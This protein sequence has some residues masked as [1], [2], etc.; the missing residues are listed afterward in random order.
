MRYVVSRKLA[1][2]VMML[3]VTGACTQDPSEIGSDFFTGGSLDF[4]SIDSASVSLSTVMFEDLQSNN[5][6]RLLVGSHNDSKLGKIQAKTFF[7]VNKP[8]SLTFPES[9]L[10]YQYCAIVLKYEGYTY[11]D[12][13]TTMTLR[14]HRVLEDFELEDDAYLY[15]DSE[16]LYQSS[17]M[18]ELTFT[19]RPHKDDSLEIKLPDT[20]GRDLYDKALNND[21]V[22]RTNDD[23][24]EWLKGFAIVSEYNDA[25][26]ILGFGIAPELRVYYTDN[27]EVPSVTKYISLPRGTAAYYFNN[28][29]SD[30]SETNIQLTSSSDRLPSEKSDDESYIQSGIG[31]ALRVE[32]P[33][34]RD[35]AQHENVFITQAILEIY[36]VRRSNENS[37]PI[38]N[39]LKPYVIDSRNDVLGE[40]TTDAT[41]IEDLE[42]ERTTRYWMD[43]TAFVKN[44]IS[45]ED[46]N[47]DA[48]A[49]FTPEFNHVVDRIYVNAAGTQYKTRLL[50]YYTMVNQ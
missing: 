25:G 18:G 40:L 32:F 44:Q 26:T 41:L 2:I 1:V 47:E 43:V 13:A 29:T 45:R 42:L 35:F 14:V 11:Y 17:P 27:N 6:T 23:L 49:F 19:P 16:V 30:Q 33:H 21:D 15:N 38:P 24:L 36:P 9:N 12:T 31:L 39:Y 7:Q 48:L 37:A 20:F 4:S 50:M 5:S 28:I 10:T 46:S 8:S 22:L 3:F 34:L